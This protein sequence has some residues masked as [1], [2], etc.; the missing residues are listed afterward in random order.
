[1]E[2]CRYMYMH[3]KLYFFFQKIKTI[4]FNNTANRIAGHL[5]ILYS[6]YSTDVC[7]YNGKFNE[8]D[9]SNCV[10]IFSWKRCH[11]WLSNIFIFIIFSD[12]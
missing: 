7:I 8:C 4:F 10:P 12:F 9:L 2:L 6:I 5:F 1:M 11:N 3:N